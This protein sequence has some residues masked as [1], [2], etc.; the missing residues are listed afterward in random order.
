MSERMTP[1]VKDWGIP[2]R[3][4][5]F[6]RNDTVIL[7]LATGRPHAKKRCEL[8]S[9]ANGLDWEKIGDF[10]AADTRQSTT[11]QPFITSHGTMLVPVW[12]VDFYTQGK[13]FFSIHRCGRDEDR[14]EKV[15]EDENGTY[16]NHFME[17]AAGES[18]YLGVGVK[19]GGAEGKIGFT[20]GSGYI[21]RSSDDGRR[22]EKVLTYSRPC[23][24][25]QGFQV[26]NGDILFTTRGQKSLVNVS[27]NTELAV[28]EAT[29]C[30]AYI[31]EWDCFVM[32][33][34]SCILLSTDAV[35]WSRVA[36]PLT[37]YALRY[38]TWVGGKVLFTAVGWRSLLVAYD[39]GRWFL[40]RDLTR[41][42]C[43]TFARMALFKDMLLCGSE[44]DGKLVII[45]ATAVESDRRK[46]GRL[47]GFTDK[48]A[49]RVFR[50]ISRRS[51]MKL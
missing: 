48:I 10:H 13:T 18:V 14:F 40:V 28:G 38:P 32:T 2:C 8:Y 24:L 12:D 29:R 44:F 17:N 6:S 31:R 23:S 51:R 47:S 22:F 20:P 27:R 15:F 37:G 1:L 49:G 26:G 21:L 45:P 3:V 34:N 11:G 46:I 41:E 35:Q 16:A 30:V 4:W 5:P 25:Y 50:A 36:F 9:S 39:S 42:T 43:S 33:G 7:S 19:G